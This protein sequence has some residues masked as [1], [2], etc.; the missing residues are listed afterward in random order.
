MNF[1][2]YDE[3]CQNPQRRI[4]SLAQIV[5]SS[6]PEALTSFISQIRSPRSRDINLGGL[7]NSTIQEAKAIYA[8]LKQAS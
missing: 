1:F 2:D 4:S 7:P 5:A 8:Q 6:N 3:L